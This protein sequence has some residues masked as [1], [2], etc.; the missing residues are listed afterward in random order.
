MFLEHFI[1]F[2]EPSITLLELSITFLEPSIMFLEHFI[3]FFEHFI[4]L[5]NRSITLLGLP[6]GLSKRYYST[7]EK[8]FYRIV[9]K[10]APFFCG[11]IDVM[12]MN[13]VVFIEVAV[14]VVVFDCTKIEAV[15]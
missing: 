6:K 12:V 10:N 8:L 1:T 3:M 15:L 2:L 11:E 7:P 13:Y 14:F 4:T 9:V 5:L